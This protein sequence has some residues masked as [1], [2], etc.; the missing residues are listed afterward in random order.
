M[1]CQNRAKRTL[2]RIIARCDQWNCD[3]NRQQHKLDVE[4]RKVLISKGWKKN[5]QF[6]NTVKSERKQHQS[7]EVNKVLIVVSFA[8]WKPIIM[9]WRE[10]NKK[11]KKKKKLYTKLIIKSAKPNSYS[12]FAFLS[13]CCLDQ[14]KRQSI[15]LIGKHCKQLVQTNTTSRL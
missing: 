11:S 14:T 12:V 15:H 6:N 13:I 9:N 8:Y 2:N 7:N 5:N 10:S 1:H 4:I 3:E